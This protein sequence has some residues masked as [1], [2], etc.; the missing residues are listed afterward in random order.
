MGFFC[1]TIVQNVICAVD[2]LVEIGEFLKKEKF[3][4][5]ISCENW[6]NFGSIK[7]KR[8]LLWNWQV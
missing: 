1:V 7:L 4:L 6:Y 2:V 3:W 8:R 5:V